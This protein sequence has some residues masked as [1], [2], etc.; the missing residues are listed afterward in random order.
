VPVWDGTPNLVDRTTIEIVQ[1][2]ISTTWDLAGSMKKAAE[3]QDLSRFGE[4][5]RK[6]ISFC[7][8]LP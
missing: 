4:T 6:I 8:R 3:I 2:T 1:S 7:S 5:K